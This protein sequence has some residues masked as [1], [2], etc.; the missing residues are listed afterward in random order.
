M[1]AKEQKRRVRTYED[2]NGDRVEWVYRKPNSEA[3]QRAILKLI[4]SPRWEVSPERG[5]VW[6][7]SR[8]GGKEIRREQGCI[9]GSKHAEV[10]FYDAEERRNFW[11]RR[12]RIVWL[13]AH[14]GTTIPH[15]HV[16]L[17]LS[18]D[19][20]DDK[21]SNLRMVPQRVSAAVGGIL[22]RPTGASKDDPCTS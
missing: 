7:L 17:H 11:L 8:R 21:I 6:L 18:P 4:S 5:K 3:N 9:V 2:D 20:S 15:D 10:R 13:A 1:I 12:A 19:L 14:P 22:S 16:V